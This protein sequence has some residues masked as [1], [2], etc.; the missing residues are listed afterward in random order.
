VPEADEDLRLKRLMDEEYWRHPFYG[1]RRMTVYRRGQGHA[2]NRQRVQRL[3]REMGL[4]A[5]GP[6]P[7][8]SRKLPP[9]PIYPYWLRDLVIERASQVWSTDIPYVPLAHGFAYWVAIRDWYSRRILAWRVSNT[10]DA[11]FCVDC[12]PQA[13]ADFGVPAIFNTDQGG[14]FTSDAFTS[15]LKRHGIAIRR[16]GRGR[17]LDNIFIERLWRSV[18]YEDIYL[19]GYA[20]IP[21][22]VVGLS[23]YFA[24]YNNKRPHQSLDYRTPSV[25][26]KESV[27]QQRQSQ[28]TTAAPAA[29][30]K[31]S[32]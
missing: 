19:N 4:Q 1:R 3:L 12:L 32:P 24:F 23:N 14:Q 22:L 8:T 6:K 13:I 28:A 17:A 31:A 20:T 2:S 11:R 25:V 5:L 10:L 18:K 9:H 30:A 16:D 15:E 26:Y 21:E 27:Q 7:N 29:D